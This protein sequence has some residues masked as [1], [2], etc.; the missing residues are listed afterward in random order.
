MARKIEY[1]IIINMKIRCTSRS[2]VRE[3]KRE[4]SSTH[5]EE[6]ID[7][8]VGFVGRAH[9]EPSPVGHALLREGHVRLSQLAVVVCEHW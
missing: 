7:V 4:K 9:E 5:I 3:V 8:F 6:T 2:Q 1:L